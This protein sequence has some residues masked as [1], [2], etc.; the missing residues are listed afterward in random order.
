VLE[1]GIEEERE[2]ASAETRLDEAARGLR[3][4][5]TS[6][7]GQAGRRFGPCKSGVGRTPPLQ[8]RARLQA[9]LRAALSRSG[10]RP[11]RRL[12]HGPK[13][14]P[15]GR[16]PKSALDAVHGAPHPAGSSAPP[17]APAHS[18]FPAPA[19]EVLLK[20]AALPL[21]RFERR[22]PLS[23][24]RCASAACCR[25]ERS[26]GS[27]P[28]GR[29]AASSTSNLRTRPGAPPTPAAAPGRRP[30]PER[31][32]GRLRALVL[33]VWASGVTVMFPPSRYP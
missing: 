5:R 6:A 29:G 23:W 20:L 28:A 3:R 13:R 7:N 19:P 18:S 26:A 21:R 27:E 30:P 10:K 22:L 11:H 33:R 16:S 15:P 17:P 32:V 8:L 9:T 31:H 25:R 2:Q 14:G 1:R 24:A 4:A 12:L